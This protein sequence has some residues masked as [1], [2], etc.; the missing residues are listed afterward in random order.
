MLLNILGI[1]IDEAIQLLMVGSDTSYNAVMKV[2]ENEE[3]RIVHECVTGK[4]IK[5]SYDYY[6]TFSIQGV[7]MNARK[8]VSKY[9][10]KI[11]K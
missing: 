11:W 7:P 2:T 6:G 10:D 4:T 8:E 9:Q 1:P 5:L 3:Y